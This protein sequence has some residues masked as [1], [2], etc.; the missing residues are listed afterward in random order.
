M[1][2]FIGVPADQRIT[3]VV[4]IDEVSYWSRKNETRS[5]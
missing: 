2:V 4:K 1:I 5:R 3:L